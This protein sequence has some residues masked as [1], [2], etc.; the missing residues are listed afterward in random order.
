MWRLIFCSGLYCPDFCCTAVRC[1]CI[2]LLHCTLKSPAPTP[3]PH[4]PH[5]TIPYPPTLS[6]HSTSGQWFPVHSA[7]SHASQSLHSHPLAALCVMHL[8]YV[9]KIPSPPN[10]IPCFAL[11]LKKERSET[12]AGHL[13][14]GAWTCFKEAEIV[15]FT[16]PGL[17]PNASHLDWK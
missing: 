5:T 8:T 7:G 14:H 15:G 16:W 6:C 13:M 11:F 4:P 12:A 2:P 17:L 9:W 10:V 1:T 3:L